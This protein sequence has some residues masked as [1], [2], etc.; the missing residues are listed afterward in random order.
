MTVEMCEA[1]V[2]VSVTASPSCASWYIQYSSKKPALVRE[3]A[4]MFLRHTELPLTK[5]N[6]L[7]RAAI[8]SELWPSWK[9]CSSYS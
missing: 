1:R 5:L 8:Y 9:A 6:C 3:S 4:H 7:K 2:P